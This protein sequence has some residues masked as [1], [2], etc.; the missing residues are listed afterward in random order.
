MKTNHVALLN[1][2][3]FIRIVYSKVDQNWIVTIWKCV[4]K[5]D[6]TMK[7]P[8]FI[9]LLKIVIQKLS[10]IKFITNDL[11]R[12]PIRSLYESELCVLCTYIE[13]DIH[14]ILNWAHMP[15]SK[16]LIRQDEACQACLDKFKF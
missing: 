2:P 15:F 7:F 1:I 11:N 5:C 6:S 3:L 10:G 16:C 13:F 9:L 4:D 8:N 14:S 12:I